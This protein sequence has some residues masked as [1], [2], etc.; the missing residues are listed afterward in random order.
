MVDL[1][2][3]IVTYNTCDLTFECLKSI[4]NHKWQISFEVILVDN[5]SSDF[6][7]E[8]VKKNFPK[9]LI[10]E[11]K[12]NGGFSKGNN[13]GIIKARSEYCLLLNSDTK[14]LPGSLDKLVEFAKTKNF[15]VVSCRLLYQDGTFQHNGGYLPTF[16]PLLLWL[17][18]LD[19][20]LSV[21]GIKTASYHLKDERQYQDEK[22][23]GWVAGTAMLIKKEVF[24]CVGLLD[25]KIFM[26]GED[27]EFCFRVNKFGY[28]VGWTNDATIIHIGGGSQKF[29][30]LAQ[31]RGEFKGLL[32]LYKKHYG[33]LAAG[34]LKLAIYI[35]TMLRMLAFCLLGKFSY[36]FTYAKI[37]T[38][39]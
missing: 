23:L 26:Y 36:T 2:I 17:S 11:S 10:I 34:G 31:W 18:G 28:T 4:Y 15:P 38:T 30:Q 3:I 35:F 39:I 29:P 21:V 33:R 25:E 37:I 24:D 20:I 14:V 6:T 32:Y 27:V 22:N 13:L 5:N 19:D 7:V 12:Q 9:V 8:S 16:G 1:S